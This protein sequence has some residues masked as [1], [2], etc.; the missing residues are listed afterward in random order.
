[1]STVGGR[2]GELPGAGTAARG[3]I[4]TVDTVSNAE[5]A[6]QERGPIPG[7]RLPMP[8]ERVSCTTLSQTRPAA[9][10]LVGLE[11]RVMVEYSRVDEQTGRGWVHLVRQ[12]SRDDPELAAELTRLRPAV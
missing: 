8:G 5:P 6:H 7:V 9:V 12:Y 10:E 1:M 11:D 3:D 4:G 2:T